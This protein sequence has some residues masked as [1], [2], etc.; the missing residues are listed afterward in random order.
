MSTEDRSAGPG[1]EPPGPLGGLDDEGLLAALRELLSHDEPP[2][3]SVNLAKSSYGLR[4]LDA[5]LVRLTSDSGLATARS[6][7]RSGAASRLVVFDAADLS[8]EIEIEIEPGERAGSWRL[9]G[10]LSPG[11]PAR[12]Q[13]RQQRAEPVW[14]DADDRGRFTADHLVGAPLSLICAREG[15][16]A[17]VTEWIPLG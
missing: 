13:V 4:A 6:V 9:I 12:I 11:T 14:V 10:Q 17:A 3:W 5:E 8:L 7:V 16:R 15:M 1:D 2:A